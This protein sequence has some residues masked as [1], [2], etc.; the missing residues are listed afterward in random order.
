M[1]LLVNKNGNGEEKEE[2]KTKKKT[3]KKTKEHDVSWQRH[4]PREQTSV[5]VSYPEAW[6][7]RLCKGAY[8]LLYSATP[9]S[10]HSTVLAKY[11]RWHMCGSPRWMVAPR[12]TARTG[13]AL[14][15]QLRL[16]AAFVFLPLC[17]LRV[18]LCFLMLI[19]D[20][21]RVSISSHFTPVLL[22]FYPHRWFAY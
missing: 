16:C 5:L 22:L 20:R 11:A 6:C 18:L 1:V 12:Y 3:K 17:A 19:I 4:A 13:P 8:H 14:V 21:P 9:C 7:K 10:W 2:E 15:A